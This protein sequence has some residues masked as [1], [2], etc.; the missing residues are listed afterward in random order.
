MRKRE[1]DQRGVNMKEQMA[2]LGPK[3]TFSDTA[4]WKVQEKTGQPIKALYCPSIEAVFDEVGRT[5]DCG[6]VPVE[7]TL[8][9]YVQGTLDKLLETKARIVGEVYVPVQF[10]LVGNVQSKEEIQRIYVQFKAKGQCLQLLSTMPEVPLV[11]TESNME[12]Y[13]MAERGI[14]GQAAIVPQHMCR[15]SACAW[16]LEN[17]TDAKNN[18]TRFFVLDDRPAHVQD[19]TH[20]QSKLALYVINAADKPGT[21]FEILKAFAENH[22][23]LAAIMSR[24]TK[25]GIG[26]YNF[27]LEVSVESGQ[28][29]LLN[30]TIEELSAQ[31]TIK[32]LGAFT[33]I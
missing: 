23:N 26:T 19:L 29:D 15:K 27:Y 10:A 30:R 7:N 6:I 24:P 33:Q 2:V 16:K 3:G 28:R 13:D 9:G 12:S 17:V 31:F 25:K 11:L 14:S 1:S 8:D 32:V 21:L 5:C 22:I 4:L 20:G 18:F